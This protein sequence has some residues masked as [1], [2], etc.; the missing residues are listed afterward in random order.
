M[1]ATI[2]WLILIGLAVIMG[3]IALA[4]LHPIWKNNRDIPWPALIYF[5]LVMPIGSLLVYL[6]LGRPAFIG[7]F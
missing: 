7:L 6:W 4:I 5:I 3:G 1:T 2:G